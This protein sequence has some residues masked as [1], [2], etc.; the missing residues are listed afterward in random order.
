[1]EHEYNNMKAAEISV[2]N[3]WISSLVAGCRKAINWEKAK[4]KSWR[5]IYFLHSKLEL[6]LLT[7]TSFP[8]FCLISFG[9]NMFSDYL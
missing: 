9:F 7:L 3:T 5:L 1:M 8:V 6:F 2:P 4:T